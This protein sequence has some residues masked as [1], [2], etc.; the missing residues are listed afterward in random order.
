MKGTLAGNPPLTVETIVSSYQPSQPSQPLIAYIQISG[1]LKHQPFIDQIVVSL[2]TTVSLA[3]V[4][5]EPWEPWEP[6]E[7]GRDPALQFFLEVWIAFFATPK[8][9]K[10]RPKSVRFQDVI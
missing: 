8:G 9:I 6:W 3:T 1:W 4:L 2:R 7:P 5:Q 10:K